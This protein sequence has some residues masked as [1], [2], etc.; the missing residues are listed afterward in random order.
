MMWAEEKDRRERKTR[1]T[2]GGFTVLAHSARTETPAAQT[3]DTVYGEYT[4]LTK[5]PKGSCGDKEIR[6]PDK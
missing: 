2:F 6:T 4:K 5:E 1:P 3:D